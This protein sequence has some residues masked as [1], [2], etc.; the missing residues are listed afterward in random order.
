MASLNKYIW[1][2]EFGSR[3]LIFTAENGEKKAS[4]FIENPTK[5]DVWGSSGAFLEPL[6]KH[7]GHMLPKDWIL[8]AFGSALGAQDDQFGSN[9]EAQDPPKSMQERE[10]VDVKK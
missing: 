2:L 9:L 8:E 4:Q 3:E 1:Y 5:I 6:G 7:L 10:K